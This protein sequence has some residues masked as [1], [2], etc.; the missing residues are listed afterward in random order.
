M[1]FLLT[2]SLPI[3]HYG[4]KIK[5]VKRRRNPS[6]FKQILLVSDIRNLKITV[7]GMPVYNDVRK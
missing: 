4:H 5:E 1:S 3:K 6:I 7:W 2:E